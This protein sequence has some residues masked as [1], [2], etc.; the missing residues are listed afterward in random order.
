MNYMLPNESVSHAFIG[1][2]Y[3]QPIGQPAMPMQTGGMNPPRQIGYAPAMN[4][5]AQMAPHYNRLAMLMRGM[6]NQPNG[7]NNRLGGMG[8]FGLERF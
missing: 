2:G 6:G 8:G 3:G 4:P 1:N 7:Y 5:F